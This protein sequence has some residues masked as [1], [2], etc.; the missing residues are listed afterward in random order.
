MPPSYQGAHRELKPVLPDTLVSLNV[1][2][3]FIAVFAIL[4]ASVL[5]S[6]NNFVGT[7]FTH[8]F[9]SVSVVPDFML[10]PL[11]FLNNIFCSVR[12]LSAF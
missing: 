2:R 3:L 7:I 12:K 6:L 8:S 11:A 9:S 10:A 4:N 1:R 5:F